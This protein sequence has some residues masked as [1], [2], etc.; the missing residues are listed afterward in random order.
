MAHHHPVWAKPGPC[1]CPHPSPP[2]PT[3]APCLCLL[4]PPSPGVRTGSDM[5]GPWLSAPIA[6]DLGGQPHY[7]SPQMLPS[8]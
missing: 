8:Q 1:T 7:W 3:P 5:Q 4:S 6:M 2:H